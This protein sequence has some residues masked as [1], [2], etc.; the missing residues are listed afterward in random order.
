MR[1]KITIV[2]AGMVGAATAQRLIE[3]DYADVVL[4]D[5]VPGMPQGKALDMQESAPILGF[6]GRIVGT[7]SYEDT[8]GSSIVVIT[9]GV[10]RKPGMSRDDL[11]QTNQKIITQVTEQIVRYSTDCIIL[12]L[13]NPVD[14][15]TQLAYRVSGLPK[16]RVVG[17]AGILDTARF[18]TFIALEL[19]VSPRDVQSYVLGG[20]GDQMVPLP[21]FTLVGGV[22]LPN[23]LPAD[24]IAALVERTRKGGEEIV[25]LLQTGSAYYAPSAALVEMI[26]AV[27][28][29][30]KRILP[31]VAYLDGEYGIRGL[32]VGVPVKLGASG[33][34]EVIELPLTDEERAELQR[35][36]DTVRTLI[37][38]MGI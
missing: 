25:K 34:E 23:L 38:K 12:M 26:D 2:G 28:L 1:Q 27:A 9:S 16:N 8:A 19:G 20:H 14:A 6:S 15:M 24:R 33:V 18:R 35:S 10:A 31:S 5:I 29:D 7:N 17:Q 11:L 21:R 32:Y 37:D 22:P 30:Q 3:R 4:L 36:A 13:T